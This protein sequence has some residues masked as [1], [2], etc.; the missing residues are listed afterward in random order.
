MRIV[1]P[2]QQVFD[3]K[4]IRVS[5]QGRVV[6]EGAERVLDAPSKAALEEALRLKEEMGCTVDVIALGDPEVE[7]ALREAQAMGADSAYLLSDPAFAG[8]DAGVVAYV[9]SVGIQ[10]SGEYDL[11]IVGEGSAISGPMLAEHLGLPQITNAANLQISQGKITGQ[12]AWGSGVRSVTAPLPALVTVPPGA[13][14]PRYAHAARVMTVFSEPTLTI[15][16]AADLGLEASQVGAAAA[17]TQ[18]RRTTVPEAR[19]LGEKITGTPEEQARWL[20]AKLRA[21]GIL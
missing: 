17:Q 4:Q 16:T 3:P 7:E 21:R 5:S 9:L 6:T 10:R 14:S 13:N 19:T 18:I 20:V 11:V 15:W 12:Q 2:I 1:V 8:S